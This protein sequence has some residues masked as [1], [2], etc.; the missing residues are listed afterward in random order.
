MDFSSQPK[1]SKAEWQSVEEPVPAD[2]QLILKLIIDGYNNVNVRHNNH[3]SLISIAKLEKSDIIENYLYHKFFKP[4]VIE[5]ISFRGLPKQITD[6][7]VAEMHLKQLKKSDKI[8]LDNMSNIDAANP[9]FEYILLGFAKEMLQ[10][11]SPAVRNNRYAFYLYTL[12]QLRHV[13][14]D[15][16]NAYV[17]EFIDLIIQVVRDA[18]QLSNIISNSY[19]FIEKNPHIYKYGDISLYDHQKRLFTVFKNARKQQLQQQQQQQQFRYNQNARLNANISNLVLYI[20]PTGTGKTLSPIGLS[21]EYRIIYVCAARHIG[22]ALAKSAISV[23]K[24]TAFAFGCETAAD[25]RLH[26]YSALSYTINKRSGGIGK[27]DNSVGNKVEIM[28]CDAKSYL[29]AMYYMLSFNNAANIITYWDEPT[30]GMDST[31]PNNV[32]HEI[33]HRN[34]SE[35]KIPNMVLSS[36]TLPSTSELEPVL[37][38]FRMKFDNVVITEINSYDCNKSITLLNKNGYTVCPHL[39]HEDYDKMLEC[40]EFCQSNKTLLRYFD[41]SEVVRFIEHMTKA[42]SLPEHYSADEYFDHSIEK[43]KMNSIKM[44][45]MDLLKQIERAAWPFIYRS[46]KDS[47]RRNMPGE[48]IFEEK[49]GIH[50]SISMDGHRAANDSGP[51]PLKRMNSVF[52]PAA[53]PKTPLELAREK[54]ESAG[55]ILLTTVDAHTLTDGPTIYL[56]EDVD[57]IGAFYVQQSNIPKDVFDGIMKVIVH[58]NAVLKSVELLELELED[59]IAKDTKSESDKKQSDKKRAEGLSNEARRIDERIDALKSQI[60]LVTLDPIYIPNTVAHQSI[61]VSEDKSKTVENAFVPYIDPVSAREIMSLDISDS[62]K[63]LLLLGIGVFSFSNDSTYSE[64]IKK[65]A[66]NKQLFIIVASSDYIYGTN[67][68]FC[69]GFIGK[70]LLN[71]TQQKTIQALGRIGRNNIQQEYSARFR[72]DAIIENLFKRQTE[73]V[74]AVNMCRILRT[75]ADDDE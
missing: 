50:K 60:Q 21:N 68:Q 71:M 9:P 62:L 64:I 61:W 27:V 66:Y 31:N 42:G 19:E 5:A 48:R 65:L 7:K 1:L 54:S 74:E 23:Q 11:F 73:N 6:F 28:I 20:A 18:T 13:T 59:V 30:I 57:K 67:Y 22:I 14:V 35:N 32:L 41:L 24:C 36:A 70:D 37:D 53:K 33:T 26:Y 25:I 55:R 10:L 2:E 56:A 29:V 39:L 16:L 72:D 47:L 3:N 40:V 44:Y 63:V 15:K 45:Y 49:D 75:D 17:L 51:A 46:M 4:R 52:I 34:W 8:R 12:I 58:N 69:H 38:D 43:I